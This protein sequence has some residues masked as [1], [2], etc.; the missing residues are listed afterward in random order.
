MNNLEY[1]SIPALEDN[2]IW[3]ISNGRDAV[4]VDPGDAA[5]VIRVLFK[6]NLRLTAILL[7]HHH[8]DHIGGVI[9]L[10]NNQID[11]KPIIVYGPEVEKISIVTHP[12]IGGERLTISILPVTFDVLKVPGHTRGHLAYFQAVPDANSDGISLTTS[13]SSIVPRVF[14]GDTLFSC[15]CGRLFE[16]T[17]VQMLTSLDVL[18]ELPSNTHIHCAHEYTLSNIC[19]ALLCEPK[20]T[21]L[22]SWYNEAYERRRLGKSTLPTTIE[23]ELAVNPFLRVSRLEIRETLER[24][25]RKTVSDR[26]TAFTM[27]RD[28]KDKF[29]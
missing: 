17:P 24:S 6:R 8:I 16:G 23:H 7:T 10:I 9:E 11:D 29:S 13:S 22:M 5:P 4:V 27:M 14:C 21:K 15:G 12:L 3:L 2:Y 25:L 19:F 20:N 28:W 18:A 26:I 1:I